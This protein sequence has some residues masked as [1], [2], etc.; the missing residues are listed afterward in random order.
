MK[1]I[2]R[3]GVL[4]IKEKKIFEYKGKKLALHRPAL[5]IKN[6]QVSEYTTGLRIP[7]AY[8]ET[9]SQAISAAEI[10]INLV[11]EK[12]PDAFRRAMSTATV[13]NPI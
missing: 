2:G 5:S 10:T 3:N 1:I 6:W 8:G 9:I 4:E 12:D 13:L 7:N 11:M